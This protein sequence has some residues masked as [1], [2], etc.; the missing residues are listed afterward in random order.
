M[1]YLTFTIVLLIWIK[2]INIESKIERIEYEL[3][4]QNENGR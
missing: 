1:E 3:K 2:I 4:K